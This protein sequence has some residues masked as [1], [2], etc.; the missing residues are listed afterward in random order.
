MDSKG[1]KEWKT[2]TEKNVGKVVA[3]T[4]DNRVY[5]APMVVMLF[6]TVELRF[7]ETLLRKKL[8]NWLMF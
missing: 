1:A 8:K 7:L 3:V 5:T 6:L 4:L 2:M